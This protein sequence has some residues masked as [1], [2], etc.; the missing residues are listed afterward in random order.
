MAL[1]T[2]HLKVRTAGFFPHVISKPMP[3][4]KHILFSESTIQTPTSLFWELSK[5]SILW[6]I[7]ILCD[8]L[9]SISFRYLFRFVSYL[10]LAIMLK[11][12][13]NVYVDYIIISSS[14]LDYILTWWKL[15][16]YAMVI[17]PEQLVIS[18]LF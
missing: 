6:I 8:V 17:L 14:N 7:T 16:E 2:R 5:R 12:N 11:L 15:F 10:L 1:T 9:F 4:K 3:Q 13:E 18:L